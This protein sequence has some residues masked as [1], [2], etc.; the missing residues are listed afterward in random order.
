MYDNA[1]VVNDYVCFH[2]FPTLMHSFEEGRHKISNI[3]AVKD[4]FE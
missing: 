3:N 1:K 2:Y 4:C